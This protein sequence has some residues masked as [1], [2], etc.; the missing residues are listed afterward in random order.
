MDYRVEHQTDIVMDEDSR[1]S[2]VSV[3]SNNGH[4]DS[5]SSQFTVNAKNEYDVKVSSMISILQLSLI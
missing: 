3:N 5:T 4:T 1:D 2:G